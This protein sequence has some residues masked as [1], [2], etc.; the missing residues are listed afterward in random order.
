MK[1]NLKRIL[2]SPLTDIGC[3]LFIISSIFTSEPYLLMLTAAQLIFVPIMLQLLTDI[4]RIHIIFI[5][6]GMIA[7]SLMPVVTSVTGQIILALI[8]LIYTLFVM[9]LGL[10][11]F[12]TVNRASWSDISINAG[13][14][15]L[16]VGGLWYFAY[17]AGIDTGF[18]PLITWLTA[19]HFHYSAF[20]L[21]VSIGFFGRLHHSA[22]YKYIVTIILA[23][24][25]L[26]AAGITFSK[27]LELVSVLLYIAAL[28]TLI[29][30]AFR[31]SF[32][33]RMQGALVRVSYSAL[34]VTILFSLLYAAGNLF[35]EW[36]IS[37]H[38]MLAFHGLLNCVVF[39]LAGVVG[40]A[41]DT[42]EKTESELNFP[43]SRIRGKLKGEGSQK[44]GLVNNLNVFVEASRL[45]QS[46]VHF[47]EQTSEYR[48]FASVNWAVWFK[49]FAIIYKLF[50][51]QWQQLNLPLSS[52]EVEMTGEILSVD[53]MVDGREDPRVWIRKVDNETVFSAI[54]SQHETDGRP[55]LNIAL[56]LPFSTMIGILQL[57]EINRSLVLKSEGGGDAG[58]YLAA[59]KTLFRLPLS[60]HFIIEETE[61]GL[62]VAMHKMKVFGV[63]FLRIDYRIIQ[64]EMSAISKR[65]D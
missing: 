10:L 43:V 15:Y 50:S 1:A 33:S 9:V 48:L 3:L 28:Y 20:L 51:T 41:I 34:G 32:S 25:M 49:P 16:F 17:I 36:A 23:G 46:I 65:F 42:P 7:V 35:G 11:R 2:F 53:S 37:I 31:T 4:K 29:I 18:S 54:Y 19:I 63:P 26:V 61:E 57:E 58:I 13:M 24:P 22:S 47:Y 6:S 39:G 38:F 45:P 52:K 14:M 21:P 55:Y 5:G 64:K 12:F 44:P 56:P 60:E 40:W 30:L 8:Y 59:G 27:W 62:L